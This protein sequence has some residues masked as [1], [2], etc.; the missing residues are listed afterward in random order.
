MH[1]NIVIMHVWCNAWIFKIKSS[2]TNP[3]FHQFLKNP[4]NFQKPKI[5]GFKTWNACKWRRLEAYQVKKNLKKLENP[6]GRGLELVREV[7][8]MKR[9]RYR[10]RDRQKLA[11]DRMRRIYIP[12][13]NLDRWGVEVVSRHLSSRWREKQRQQIMCREAVEE[14]K[15][16][17]QDMRI[18]RSNKCRGAVERSETYSIDPLGIEVLLRLR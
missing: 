7:W 11:A 15:H 5:L 18:D 1:E 12:S 4:K 13:V 8:E 16:Q 9:Q 17:N 14:K 2:K 6:K 10:E 3:K